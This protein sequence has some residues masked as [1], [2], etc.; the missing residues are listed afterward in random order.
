MIPRQGTAPFTV[1]HDALIVGFVRSDG[2]HVVVLGV[3]DFQSSTY[4][5]S[6]GEGRVVVKTRNDTDVEQRHSLVVSTGKDWQRTADAAFYAARE[7]GRRSIDTQPEAEVEE[8]PVPEP[9]WY[10][11]WW[12]Y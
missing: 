2:Q 4:L 9:A 7:M 12:V 5:T 11:T 1:D 10:E 6:D 8:E 3:S